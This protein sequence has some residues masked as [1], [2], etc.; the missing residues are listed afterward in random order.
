MIEEFILR[1]IA[2]KNQ[3]TFRNVL[4]EYLQHLFLSS[5][6]KRKG[7]E[8][9]LFKGGTALKLIFGSPRFSEDIDF[10]GIK[11][12]FLYEDILAEVLS[13]LALENLEVELQESKKTSGGHLAIL[14]IVA[15][16]E[17][18]ALFQET[19]FR[20]LISAAK[21]F[22][23][24]TS[25]LTPTYGIYSLDKGALISE[26]IKA[27]LFRQK[28]RDFFDLYFIL[29][30]DELRQSL[31]LKP[32][33]RKAVFNSLARQRKEVL[34]RELKDFLPKSF[35]PVIEDLPEKI[36]RELNFTD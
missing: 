35:W 28:P 10:S 22:V 13:D 32:E 20:P 11:N 6:Y 29:R 26:K 36:K 9:F 23:M 16:G 31:R 18:L 12:S 2:L 19:S 1:K 25:G 3:T 33:E 5:F 8:N 21:E 4:R 7:S 34:E 27:L 24:V 14:K 15:F 30:K 17:E